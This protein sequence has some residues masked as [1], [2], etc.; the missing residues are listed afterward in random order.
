VAGARHATGPLDPARG[1]H[2]HPDR[3][4]RPLGGGGPSHHQLEH[5]RS[6]F[7]CAR[8]PNEPRHRHTS[9]ITFRAPRCG[10]RKPA[11]SHRGAPGTQLAG[12]GV[13]A[14]VRLAFM[15]GP[16]LG[17]ATG[18]LIDGITGAT[19]GLLIPMGP[20]VVA[21]LPGGL[22]AALRPLR[23]VRPSKPS[24]QAGRAGSSPT[25]EVKG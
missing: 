23:P 3:G 25:Q 14:I 9:V 16:L 21:W 20:A 7:T 10:A 18:Y 12:L 22:D 11:R 5:M 8:Y 2:A 4:A 19:S 1:A 13:M 24:D 6:F 17:A 15:F